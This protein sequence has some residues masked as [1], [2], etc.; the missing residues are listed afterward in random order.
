MNNMITQNDRSLTGQYRFDTRT[1]GFKTLV[2]LQVQ[3]THI[4]TM[5]DPDA[6]VGS[7]VRWR[8]A[9]AGDLTQ[10]SHVLKGH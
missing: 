10:L 9:T 3:E 2:V 6:Q 4:P 1:C 8:D 7:F 5:S